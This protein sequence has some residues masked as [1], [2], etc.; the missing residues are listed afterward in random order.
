MFKI[1][2]FIF[3]DLKCHVERINENKV[4]DWKPSVD[5]SPVAQ[6]VVDL[7]VVNL[8]KTMFQTTWLLLVVAY[9]LFGKCAQ[10]WPF[11]HAQQCRVSAVTGRQSYCEYMLFQLEL[12]YDI[13]NYEERVT[14]LV[15]MH[16]IVTYLRKKARYVFAKKRKIS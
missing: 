11:L 1:Y 15:K 6:L 10:M 14:F 2:Y 5:L 16:E 7:P 3:L 8:W 9:S 12:Q 13:K 4:S